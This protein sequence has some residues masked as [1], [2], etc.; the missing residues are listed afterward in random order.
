MSRARDILALYSWDAGFR[1]AGHMNTALVSRL[2]SVSLV[3]LLIRDAALAL[4]IITSG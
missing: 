4:L 2:L 3:S 1:D